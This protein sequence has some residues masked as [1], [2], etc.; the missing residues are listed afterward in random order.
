[1]TGL[2]TSDVSSKNSKQLRKLEKQSDVKSGAFADHDP[3]LQ[4]LNTRW[5]G[6]PEKV[7]AI[8]T[9]LVEAASNE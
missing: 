7:K 1:M 5:H 6:L 2:Y 3:R 8:I 9:A 4:L